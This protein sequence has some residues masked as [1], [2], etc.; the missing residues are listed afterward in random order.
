M[1]KKNKIPKTIGG[2]GIAILLAYAF[3]VIISYPKLEVSYLER[4]YKGDTSYMTN[5]NLLINKKASEGFSESSEICF[6]I[7][8]I[9][10]AV[11]VIIPASNLNSYVKTDAECSNCN[12]STDLRTLD[13]QSSNQICREVLVEKD[14]QQV[15]FEVINSLTALG[16]PLKSTT[17]FNCEKTNEESFKI[18]YHCNKI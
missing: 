17:K 4:S 1:G 5:F 8:N 16:I 3:L 9:A 14:T 18:D 11:Q 6:Q 13:A 7:K 12:L 10:E 15:N 2:V